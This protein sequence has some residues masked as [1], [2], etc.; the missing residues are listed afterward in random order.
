VEITALPGTPEASRVVAY[1]IATDRGF[2]VLRIL[3]HPDA[4]STRA[5]ELAVVPLLIEFAAP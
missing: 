2:G 3:G 4:V 5:D 1:A